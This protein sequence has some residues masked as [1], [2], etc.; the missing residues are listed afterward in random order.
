MGQGHAGGYA[1]WDDDEFDEMGGIGGGMDDN[2]D[3]EKTEPGFLIG[4]KNDTEEGEDLDSKNSFFGRNKKVSL[5][6]SSWQKGNVM[7]SDFMTTEEYENE[8][9]AKKKK[10]KEKG[11]KKSK[12]SKKKDSKKKH[13]RKKL[14]ND[15]DE[16]G[17]EFSKQNE[18]TKST[19]LQDL[20]SSAIEISVDHKRKRRV[21]DNDE[22]S[23][24]DYNEDAKISSTVE[25][26][27]KTIA[28]TEHVLN[29]NQME[30]E[31]DDLKKMQEKRAKFD[32]VMEKGNLRSKQ[33]F[34]TVTS[35]ADAPKPTSINQK[36]NESSD[37]EDND[38]A[39][40]AFLNAALAKA[41]RL[42]KLKRLHG[43]NDNSNGNEKA[44]DDK[45]AKSILEALKFSS[46]QNESKTDQVTG[47][48]PNTKGITF[49][50]DPTREFT[51]A[52]RARDSQSQR[53]SKPKTKGTLISNVNKKKNEKESVDLDE[54][55]NTAMDVDTDEEDIEKLSEQIS[56][57]NNDDDIDGLN[58]SNQSNL[59]VNRGLSSTLSLLKTTGSLAS[60]DTKTSSLQ[61][62]LRGRAKDRRNYE[63]YESL[64]L[65]KVTS[66]GSSRDRKDA[67]FTKREIKLEYRDEYGRL[68]TS[69][70]AYRQMCYQFHGHGSGKKNEE[71]RLKLI[72]R[73]RMEEAGGS[74]GIGDGLEKRE[75]TLGAL[76]ATQRVTGK[77][78]IVHKT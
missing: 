10:K 62:K 57:K 42:Q 18:G 65:G 56:T 1:A 35:S 27:K 67:E 37:Q 59:I 29:R 4:Q 33:A 49:E 78:F 34:A 45:K 46:D 14:D 51:R 2:D 70:E 6:S 55:L 52:L 26:I 20:E 13:R 41:R 21:R 7:A 74:A 75:G 61:E 48:S 24:Q 3:F 5:D 31:E 43:N 53:Q 73:E 32:A 19:L 71:R 23:N 25:D 11:F 9:E 22:D 17:K 72:E 64:D 36:Q 44:T 47:T 28:G 54:P 16:E 77:A 76:K 39:D 15:S 12:K 58:F 63:D 60:N 68:L 40:D 50:F 66:I 8:K 69:K 38:E 30:V